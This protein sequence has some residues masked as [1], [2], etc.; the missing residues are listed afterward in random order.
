MRKT[1]AHLGAENI[2][3]KK[4]KMEKNKKNESEREKKKSITH[5]DASRGQRRRLEPFREKRGG[6]H[7]YILFL[8]K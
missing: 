8:R 3:E 4:N 1:R 2:R 6:G 5:R 7:V